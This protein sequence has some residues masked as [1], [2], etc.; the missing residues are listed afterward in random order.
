MKLCKEH[1]LL[2]AVTDSRWL[3]NETLG[4]QVEEALKG[5]VT[6]IQLRE[7]ELNDRDF[8]NEALEIKSICRKYNSQICWRQHDNRRV[9]W[10]S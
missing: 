5:G 9:S 7:K 10:N 6:C 4:F 8:F 1:M 2:Y 3:G